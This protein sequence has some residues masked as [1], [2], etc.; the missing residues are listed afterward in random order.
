MKIEKL[1]LANVEVVSNPRLQNRKIIGIARIFALAATVV[2]LPAHELLAFTV[3]QNRVLPFPTQTVSTIP[4]NGDVNPYGVAFVP[5]NFPA[6]GK[7]NPGD[8]LVSNFNNLNNIQGTGTTIIDI[9]SSGQKSVFFQGT[10]PLGLSTGLAVLKAGFVLVAN[11]PT[12]GQA[13]VAGAAPGS[14]LLIDRNGNLVNVFTSNQIQ[15]PWDFSVYDKGDKVWVFV[16]QLRH[17]KCHHNRFGLYPSRRSRY[18]WGSS[19][20][21]GLRFA[22]RHPLCRV[23]RR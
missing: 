2:A 18:L 10:A 14:L 9:S 19:D 12:N 22:D 23:H 17:G 7:L 4:S 21:I 11:C 20:R 1:R 15:G 13:P 3:N 6:G 16:S 8:L 5:E